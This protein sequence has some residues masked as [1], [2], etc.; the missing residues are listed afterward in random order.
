[1]IL[2][3][4]GNRHVHICENGRVLH[5][6]LMDAIDQ[7]GTSEVAYIN[8]SRASGS[9]LAALDGWQDISESLSIEGEYP[10]MGIDRK[11][12]CLS[13][14]QGLFVDAGSAI[15]V[16]R[17]ID[18][19]YQG[20]FIL[21]GLHAYAKAYAEISPVLDL[22]LERDIDLTELP[23]DTRQSVS[24]GTIASIVSVIE[25]NR[26]GLPLYL[27]GGD[28]AYL[29]RYFEDAHY[30]EMLLFEGMK[31]SIQRKER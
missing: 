2:A 24:F 1:M 8:V 19:V 29:S 20:G 11:A 5:L 16:D 30:D 3:D 7:Y 26:E 10:G 15:T 27:T 31:K 12:L 22:P 6:S 25:A 13:R 21:P 17:V 14:Q 4:V 23:R 28:G 9:T 18:G